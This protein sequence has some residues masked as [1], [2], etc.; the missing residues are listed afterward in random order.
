MLGKHIVHSAMTYSLSLFGKKQDREFPGGPV[1]GLT[2]TKFQ[3][4]PGQGTKTH[5]LQGTA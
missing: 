4:D 5:K 2:S 1:V 3:V